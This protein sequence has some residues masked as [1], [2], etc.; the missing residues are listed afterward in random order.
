MIG[1]AILSTEFPMM[2]PFNHDSA[3][4][5]R[6]T[7]HPKDQPVATGADVSFH[8]EATGDDLN[9]QW[10]K[11]HS[12]LHDC[13]RYCDAHTDTL[14]IVKVEKSDKGRYSCLVKNAVGEK[15][16][17]EALLAVSKLHLT[18]HVTCAG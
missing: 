1:M 8:V 4:P 7:Q 17:D 18:C 11:N 10:Q 12:N 9:F 16:S 5:P 14:H 3:D 6:I 15:L 2:L 13:K